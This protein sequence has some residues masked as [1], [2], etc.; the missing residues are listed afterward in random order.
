MLVALW[1]MDVSM[2]RLLW[3]LPN[4]LLVAMGNMVISMVHNA[5]VPNKA[6]VR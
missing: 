4:V 2:A 1:S 3:I 5:M 6:M